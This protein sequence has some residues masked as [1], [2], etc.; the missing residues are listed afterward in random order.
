MHNLLQVVEW[1]NQTF[2]GQGLQVYGLATPL[3]T[4]FAFK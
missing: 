1:S 3:T 4:D 2:V